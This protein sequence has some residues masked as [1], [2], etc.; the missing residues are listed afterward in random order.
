MKS[1]DQADADVLTLLAILQSRKGGAPHALSRIVCIPDMWL[2]I[3]PQQGKRPPDTEWAQLHVPL[4]VQFIVGRGYSP[5]PLS[6]DEDGHFIRSGLL[7]TGV[8]EGDD[9][10]KKAKAPK[11]WL[12]PH[13]QAHLDECE[14]SGKRFALCNLGLYL[15]D[16]TTM[17]GHANALVF[18]H[19][20]SRGKRVIERFDPAY[21]KA[22]DDWGDAVDL[23]IK[24]LFRRHFP[25]WEYVG[26]RVS[27]PPKG[28]QLRA[29][30]WTGLCVTY[31]LW[32]VLLRLLNPDRSARQINRF[33]ARGSRVD[34]V[35]RAKRL[36]RFMM[37]A[38]RAHPY[39]ILR[40]AP[41]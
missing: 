9:A 4:D 7:V 3:S 35:H 18:V 8:G 2:R 15:Y 40:S 16:A 34:L 27:A 12:P 36:N 30:A 23:T 37:D 1:Y 41:V 31:S 11:L 17:S 10:S 13:F 6:S 33:M 20:D 38:L 26:T 22:S 24:A 25:G 5:S 32:Y 19:G 28:V 39:G 29:D 14:R 21:N